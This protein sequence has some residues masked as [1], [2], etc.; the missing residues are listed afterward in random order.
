MLPVR[1]EGCMEEGRQPCSSPIDVLR[2][3]FL[4]ERG[5]VPRPPPAAV[6]ENERRLAGRPT[7][8]TFEL[9]ATPTA[10]KNMALAT[11]VAGL[12]GSP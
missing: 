6:S 10:T 11:G 4:L 12:T 5:L 9:I 1:H 3:Q 7:R 8:D 2:L